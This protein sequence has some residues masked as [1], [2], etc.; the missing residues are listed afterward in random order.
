MNVLCWKCARQT[1]LSIQKLKTKTKIGV[2]RQNGTSM[3]NT[4]ANAQFVV[5]I[6]CL[7]VRF[8]NYKYNEIIQ[9]N[10]QSH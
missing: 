2:G 5:Y 7:N 10:K 8:Q 4:H 6:I 9:I 1:A 3:H